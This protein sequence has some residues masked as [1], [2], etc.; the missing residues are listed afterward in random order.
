LERKL[1]TNKLLPKLDL[2]YNF[3]STNHVAFFDGAGASPIENYKLGI[4][5]SMPLFLRK[6][7][8]DLKLNNLKQREVRYEQ[9]AKERALKVKIE[10]YFNTVQVHSNQVAQLEQIIKNYLILLEAEQLKLKMGESSVFMV[11]IR[12]KQL[13]EARLKL[14]KQQAQYL[15]ARAAFFWI[16]A[17]LSNNLN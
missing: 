6:E 4:K 15:K 10:N 14:V 13:L 11:N 2:K 7:R 16:T 8:A 17:K 12:E 1:K 9:E 5:F 3:L